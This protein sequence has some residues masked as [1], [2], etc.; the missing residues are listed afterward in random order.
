MR[1][2]PKPKTARDPK[3]LAWLRTQR[4]CNPR[5]ISDLATQVV[6]AHGRAAGT[7]L[8][9]PDTEALP[10]CYLCHLREHEGHLTFWRG[11]DRDRIV[12]EHRQRYIAG[13]SQH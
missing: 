5:C 8:K 2:D 1:P 11:I 10:L 3:Y 13:H 9:G 6:A 7:A 4:C 12:R